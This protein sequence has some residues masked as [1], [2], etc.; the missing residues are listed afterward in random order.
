MKHPEQ[1][2]NEI[3]VGNSSNGMRHLTALKTARLG[4]VAYDIHGKAITEPHYH[5]LKPL[6]ID[7]SE[8]DEYDRIM[9]A[10][11][12]YRKVN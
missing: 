2:D 5:N 12:P 10:R 9:M 3:F 1:K 4:K 7:R 6:F 8:Q 11:L